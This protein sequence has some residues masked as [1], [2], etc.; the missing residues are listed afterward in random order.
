MGGDTKEGKWPDAAAVGSLDRDA[1]RC[2]KAAQLRHEAGY[3]WAGEACMHVRHQKIRRSIESSL[4]HKR[5]CERE[6]CMPGVV[7]GT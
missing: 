2:S 7:L 1:G 3:S 6:L 5:P 4:E